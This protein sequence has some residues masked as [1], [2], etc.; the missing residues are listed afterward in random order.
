MSDSPTINSLYVEY[1]KLEKEVHFYKKLH[2]FYHF[3]SNVG[4]FG[5]NSVGKSTFLNVLVGNK[6]EF[7]QGFGETTTKVTVLYS[8][9]KP[10]LRYQVECLYLQKNYTFLKYFNLYDIPG[11]GKKY[12]HNNLKMILKELDVVLWLVDAST[13]VKESD[14]DF[15]KKLSYF[16]SNIKIIVI[17]NRMDSVVDELDS[18]LDINKDIE[19]L[20]Q[21]FIDLN[22]SKQLSAIIPFSAIKSLINVVKK[23]GGT[24]SEINRIMKSILY[25]TVF[26]SSFDKYIISLLKPIT[27]YKILFTESDMKIETDEYIDVISK[28]L[29]DKLKNEISCF[30]SLNPFGSKNEEARLYVEHAMNELNRKFQ[31]L[32]KYESHGLCNI[33]QKIENQLMKYEVFSTKY[34]PVKYPTH[35]SL[36]IDVSLENLAWD[37]FW[38]DSFA[39]DVASQF[40]RRAKREF[41]KK[42]HSFIHSDEEYLEK[43]KKSLNNAIIE[44]VEKLESDLKMSS[45]YMQQLVSYLLFFTLKESQR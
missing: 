30:S 3:K 28:N 23:E 33:V 21:E 41:G 40:R 44:S 38:G 11:Y 16:K 36:K 42:I 17:Y 45:L 5:E 22:L 34:V 39:E 7:K 4:V 18:Y 27:E 13:G 32:Y 14:K 12:S 24:F 25:Y 2:N 9:N 43:T 37:S 20:K 6:D 15:L 19:K 26:S 35:E 8:W 1:S 10:V 31:K 29:E